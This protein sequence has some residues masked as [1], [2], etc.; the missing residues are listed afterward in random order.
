MSNAGHLLPLSRPAPLPG[1]ELIGS[2][3]PLAIITVARF[4]SVFSDSGA[5]FRS[6]HAARLSL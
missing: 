5:S 1:C 2:D 3:W 4:S 6:R